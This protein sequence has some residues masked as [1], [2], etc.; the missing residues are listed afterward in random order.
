[1]SEADTPRA[2]LAV[3]GGSGFARTEAL[4]DVERWE[5]PTP[6]GSPSGPIVLGTLRG[7][8][9]AF[10]P[11]HG[12]EHTL[13]PQEVPFRANIWALKTLGV[14]G[15]IAVSAVGSLREEVA[16]GEMVVPDQIIDRTRHD[17]PTT[18]FGG[19]I[20]AH[21]GFADPF[22]AD[23]SARLLAAGAA[24]GERIHAGGTYVA[25]EGPVFSTRAESRLYRSW[26]GTIVGMTAIPEAKLAR[27]AEIAYAMLATATDYDVW[28]EGE[29]GVAVDV[30]LARLGES[31]A[32]AQRIV[33][34]TVADL[35]TDWT[36]SARGALRTAI[37]TEPARIPAQARRDLAPIIGAYLS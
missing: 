23:L 10:L 32:T 29:S 28:R 19:G 12:S 1:M 37:V 11:R 35:P 8:K 26:G 21:V 27:E 15:I 4:A 9:V 31:A 7:H 36:S 25:M 24:L 5:A 14:Q 2:H 33:S 6:F 3:I 30:I 17:R 20:V 16:P 34:A 13:L 22:C 18:F